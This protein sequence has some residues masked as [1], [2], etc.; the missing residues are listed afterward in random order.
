M[1]KK[2]AT[3]NAQIEARVLVDSSWGAVNEVI[4]VT[5]EEADAGVAAGE[6]DIHP[7]AVAYAKSLGAAQ[8]DNA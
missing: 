3:E 4:V 8:P 2:Q 6:I 5:K 7:D 1:A